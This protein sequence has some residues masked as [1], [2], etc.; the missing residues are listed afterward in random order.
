MYKKLVDVSKTIL[1]QHCV[2]FM[3]CTV[4]RLIK[5]NIVIL[6]FY[7]FNKY[8]NKCNHCNCILSVDDLANCSNVFLCKTEFSLPSEIRTRVNHRKHRE[9]FHKNNLSPITMLSVVDLVLTSI[10]LI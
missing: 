2:K 1:T 7:K 8:L 3:H 4:Y 9:N 6:Y 10:V 5:L